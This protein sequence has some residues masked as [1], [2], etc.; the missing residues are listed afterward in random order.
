MPTTPAQFAALNDSVSLNFG[1]GYL[2]G[3]QQ[4]GLEAAA[5][6]R[7]S[8]LSGGD[9]TSNWTSWTFTIDNLANNSSG[10]VTASRLSSFGFDVNPNV[11]GASATGMFD[12]STR[13]SNISNGISVEVCFR[14]SGGQCN[15][16]GSGGLELGQSIPNGA[17][18]NN[19]FTL[20]FSQ[21]QSS[22]N[23]DRF[24]VRY[25]SI[26]TLGG[27]MG[28]SGVGIVG[29]GPIDPF[30]NPVPEPASWVMLIAGFGLVG[31]VA[32]RQKPALARVTA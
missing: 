5:T 28:G 25:Q 4:P 9:G 1:D 15:G 19:T 14:D 2:S 6:F 3:V 26:N 24:V 8:S 11:S 29:E 16:G 13:N 30:G 22:I 23:L 20:L 32:R 17:F 12:L 18:P 7:L 31:A 10:S 21:A 27:V